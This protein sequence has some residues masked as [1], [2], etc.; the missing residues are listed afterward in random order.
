MVEWLVAGSALEWLCWGIALFSTALLVAKLLLGAL[1]DGLDG[2]LD[3]SFD[4]FGHGDSLPGGGLN[5]MLAGL[6]VM[7]WSGVL[8]FQMTRLSPTMVLGTAVSAGLI[9]FATTVWM[10][11]QARRIESDGTLRVANAIGNFGTVYLTIPAYGQ[12]SGQVQ[13]EVQGRLA[14]LEAVTDGPAIPTGSRVFVHSVSNGVLMVVPESLL[15]AYPS[16][17]PTSQPVEAAAG[18]QALAP[19]HEELP[20]G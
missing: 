14:T 7:G 10:L 2:H 18:R 4:L 3:G 16:S 5:A 8:C 19:S 15:S 17:E 1:L 6:M 11:R 20:H 12:G 9:T 13:I